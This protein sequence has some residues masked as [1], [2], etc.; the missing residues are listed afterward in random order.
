MQYGSRIWIT[1][2]PWIQGQGQGQ[3]QDQD[4][5]QAGLGLGPLADVMADPADTATAAAA[6]S[7][8]EVLLRDAVPEPLIF[9][10]A[11]FDAWATAAPTNTSIATGGQT[12]DRIDPR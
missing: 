2:R 6:A 1:K 12:L 10:E 11:P 5:D 8:D 4:Q 7:A 3:D 9:S